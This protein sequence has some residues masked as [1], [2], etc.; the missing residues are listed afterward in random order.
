MKRRLFTRSGFS[1]PE[2][3]IAVLILAISIAAIV[4][5]FFLSLTLN[6]ANR[7]ATIAASHAQ[8]VLENI[9][10]TDPASISTQINE[11]GWDWDGEALTSAGLTPLQGETIATTGEGSGLL[12]VTVTIDWE[13]PGSRARSFSLVTMME[14]A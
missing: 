8:F 14:G 7:N 12:T 4:S 10:N 9:R 5:F 2:L 13:D 11:G 3:L 1:I 6:Q